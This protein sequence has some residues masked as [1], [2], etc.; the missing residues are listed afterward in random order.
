MMQRGRDGGGG[1]RRGWGELAVAALVIAV[2]AMLIVPL[3]R[4]VLDVLLALNI[5]I[6]VALL[7]AAVFT[8]RPRSFG[9]FPML[10][11]VTT[12]FRVGLE[13]SATRLI[14]ADA[15]AGAVVRAFGSSVVAGNLVVGL[16]VFAVITLVQL[17][18]VSRGAERVAEVS[19]RFA[20]DAMP[21]KQLAIDAEQRA[22]ALAPE[23]ARA[24]R[25]ELER[26]SQLYGAMD[27]A[28]RFVKGDAIA[29]IVIV[30]INLI[31]GLVIGVGSR[32][33]SAAEAV[34]TYS[35][36]SIGGGLVAQIPS[37]LVAVAAGLLVTRVASTGDRALGDDLGA[38]LGLEPGGSPRV[39]TAT[40]V[41]LLALGT[42]RRAAPRI[43]GEGNALDE[44]GADPA[45]APHLALHLGPALHRRLATMP[46]PLHTQL[47]EVRASL[48][49]TT[50]VRLAPLAVAADPELADDEVCVLLGPTPVAWLTAADLPA[51]RAALPGALA[52]LVPDL[53]GVDRVA[54]LV[55]AAAATAPVLVREVVPRVIALPVLTEVLRGLVRE[56]VPIDDLAAI[57]E[58]I[59]LA[60]SPAGGLTAREVP[61]LVEHLRGALRRQISARWAP[62]GQLAVYTVDAMIEDAVRSAVDRREGAAVLAL[63][64]AIAQ[65]IVAAVKAAIGAGPAVILTSG[66]VRRHLRSRL[67]PE[68]P[69][70]AVLAAHEL[71]PGTSI[72]TAGRIDVA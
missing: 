1:G 63:E 8:P 59:A 41:L 33:L 19:A 51:L 45:H 61:A 62:R 17:I 34:K 4:V 10:L 26:E 66:D 49:A 25:A 11:V 29:A 52:P 40:S 3:P 60:P 20:L 6:A 27:G 14:L 71:A 69:D 21:G 32:G 54:A 9:S 55:D 5:A 50:G 72:R 46:G 35:L 48:T 42:A 43:V 22:G 70:V 44:P 67:A 24:R 57:L 16:V 31:G 18:V 30:V 12:L 15:D 56:Q 36:L 37:L 13:V 38:H 64:P 65:D 68:L 2:V 7:M 58:A 53:L 39:L 28:M 47:A 23:A